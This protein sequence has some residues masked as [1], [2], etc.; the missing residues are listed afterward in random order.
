MMVFPKGY[1]L[2]VVDGP[3]SLQGVPGCSGR[4]RKFYMWV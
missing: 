4:S 3:R 2:T 1:R